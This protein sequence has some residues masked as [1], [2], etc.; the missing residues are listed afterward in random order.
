MLTIKVSE[1]YSNLDEFKMHYTYLGNFYEKK[2]GESNIIPFSRDGSL[3]GKTWEGEDIQLSVL[4]LDVQNYGLKQLTIQLSSKKIERQNALSTLNQNK[5]AIDKI[6]G[7]DI[8][9]FGKTQKDYDCEYWLC[10]KKPVNLFI[11]ENKVES[12]SLNFSSSILY[13]IVIKFSTA[14]KIL[15]TLKTKYGE[16]YLEK[17]TFDKNIMKSIWTGDA[18][19][20]NFYYDNGKYYLHYYRTIKKSLNVL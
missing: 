19:T 2:Y 9:Q 5:L 14:D 11:G 13:A 18:V 8:Y 7:F 3:Y 15:E 16:P 1:R 20:I 10:E 17:D 6:A 4:T 12:I